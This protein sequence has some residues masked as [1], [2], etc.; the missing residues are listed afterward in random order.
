M[1]KNDNRKKFGK[2]S[3]KQQSLTGK[4]DLKI[5]NSKS[6]SSSKTNAPNHLNETK[7][8][9]ETSQESVPEKRP[10]FEDRIHLRRKRDLPAIYQREQVWYIVFC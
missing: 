5:D 10:F 4:P 8:T 3:M 6:T 2:H 9:S 7:R 1:R